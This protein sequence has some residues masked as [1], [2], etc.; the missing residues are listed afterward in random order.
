MEARATIFGKNQGLAS[1]DLS[2]HS[3]IQFAAIEHAPQQ[4]EVGKSEGNAVK[5]RDVER[6]ESATPLRKLGGF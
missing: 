1:S 2:K 5:T 4:Q 3:K 6:R